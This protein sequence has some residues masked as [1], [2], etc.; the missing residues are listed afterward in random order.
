MDSIE[1]E[2]FEICYGK[3]ADGKEDLNFYVVAANPDENNSKPIKE[4][5]IETIKATKG[6]STEFSI[7]G[8]K[9]GSTIEEVNAAFNINVSKDTDYFYI[10]DSADTFN[11]IYISFSDG[12]VRTLEINY[13]TY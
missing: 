9:V 5:V 7:N 2:D 12:V 10:Y 4:C 13:W 1:A 11:Y 8:I 6:A 3:M